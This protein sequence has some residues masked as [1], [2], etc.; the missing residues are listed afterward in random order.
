MIRSITILFTLIALTA[1]PTH[2]QAPAAYDPSVRV[3]F[4]RIWDATAPEKS[5]SV[6]TTRPTKDVRVTTQ[7]LDG[8]GRPIEII[9]QKASLVTDPTNPT[10]LTNATDMIIPYVYDQYGRERYAYLAFA[11]NTSGGNSSI[12]DGLFKLNP[13]QQQKYFFSDANTQSP[14]RGQGDTLFFSKT[15]YESSPLDRIQ[16]VYA[17]G[18]SW[19]GSEVNSDPNTRRNTG[20]E[21]LYNDSNDSVRIWVLSGSCFSTANT[22]VAG[23]LR[24]TVSIDEHK[25]KTVDYTDK[26]GRLVLKK[27]QFSDAPS[28]G[29]YGWLCTY[30]V[31]DDFNLLRGILQPKAIEELL[32][33]GW[34]VTSDIANELTFRYEYDERARPVVKKIPGAGEVWMVYDQWDRLVLSQTAT[35]RPQHQWLFTKYDRLNRPIM[36]GL[37]TNGTDTTLAAMQSYLNTQNLSRYETYQT[38]TFPLYSLTSTFPAVSYSDVHTITYYDDYSWAGWYGSYG[39]KDNTWDNEFAAPSTSSWPYPES[40]A[41]SSLTKGLITGVW[42]KTNSG[43]LTVNYYDPKTR[44]IQ[45][46]TLN[47]TG[48][49]DILTVQYKFSGEV[50]QTVLRHQKSGTNAQ[51]HLVQTRITYDEID[52]PV[53][54]EKKIASTIGSITLSK[55][56]YI[57]AS[58]EYDALGREKKR[59]LSPSYNNGAGLDTLR[60][61]HNIHGWLTAINKGYVEG[62]NNSWFGMQLGYDRD[63]YGP[64]SNKQYNDNISGIIWRSGGDGERRKYDFTY[65]ATKRLLRADFTQKAS[66]SWDLSAGI[67]YSVKLGNGADPLTAYD[68]NGNIKLLLQK[69][70]KLGGSVTIDSLVYKTLTSS[71]K[72]KHV[73]DAA[74]DPMSKLSDFK[75]SAQNNTDNVTS[76]IADYSYDANGN[77][78]SDKNKSI[79]SITYNHLDLPTAVTITNEGSIEYVYSSFGAKLKKIV[80][81]SGKPDKVTLY[82]AGFVYEN[83]QLQLFQYDDGRVRLMTDTGNTYTGYAFDYF[84]RDH[85]GNIRAVLTD[86]KDTAAYPEASLETAK[87]GRDTLYYS[88]I[89]ETRVPKG[90]IGGY[91][92]NDTYTSPNDWIAETNGSGNKIGPGI[93]LK[94]MAGDALNLRVSSWYKLNGASPQSPVSPLS[95]LLANLIASMGGSGKF[96]STELQGSATF[97]SNVSSFLNSRADTSGRPKAYLNWVLFDERLNYVEGS[98][99]FQQVPAETEYGNGGSSPTVKIHNKNGLA[100]AKNGYLYVFVS[101]ETPNISVYF[102][103]LQVTHFKSSLLEES[104]Y[105][106]FGIVMAG[107]SSKAHGRIENRYKF[108]EGAELSSKEFSDGVGMDLYETEFR[109]Y[110][111]QIGRFMHVDP[112]ADIS[113]HLSPYAFAANNPLSNNDPLG[114][115]DT[116]VNGQKVQRDKDLPTV[117]FVYVKKKCNSCLPNNRPT[118]T[119]YSRIEPQ[120]A[121]PSIKVDPKPIPPT[122][123]PPGIQIDKTPGRKPLLPPGMAPWLM[124]ATGT[125]GLV[126]WPMNAGGGAYTPLY[127]THPELVEHPFAPDEWGGHGNDKNNSNPH[128]V[129][130]FSFTP[131]DGQTPILKYGISD[132]F[133]NGYD[134]PEMQKAALIAQFGASVKYRIVT[135]TLNRA[136]ALFLEAALVTKHVQQWGVMPRRQ[137][138][139]KPMW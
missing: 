109:L 66:S 21:R 56:W 79:A 64:F 138:R 107:I 127:K 3:N 136:H 132:V 96:A 101:N 4:V 133:R 27:V 34:N 22:Y 51:T 106:P 24:E 129:Y 119:L 92:T 116:T 125:V 67:D 36:T 2:S 46:K 42:D 17:A 61:E 29:H 88:K 128:I 100:I 11:A 112:L 135:R 32:V 19:V 15:N 89:P 98:S 97:S 43:M 85:L 134:R 41:Q 73:H 131:T 139:P 48:G 78:T 7:Y 113:E 50:L 120:I 104:H 93:L 123:R 25:K 75:E 86:Q 103:N 52:R 91:P 30:Y 83:D 111:P 13:F 84:I 121:P 94:V 8:I 33:N 54:F 49:L 35:L 9:A 16:E 45:S 122:N 26:D 62:T 20:V 74:N 124:R 71:N 47:S 90:E 81:E 80:H 5:P 60:Y 39:S 40:L 76:D 53:Q 1:Q 31:Y 44:L 115:K 137:W 126:L 118:S 108:N 28:T 63:G 105:Y 18:N 10:A 38:A 55:S 58:V 65:D 57:V 110:D 37:Y 95:D 130:E 117:I 114:L 59:K 68:A 77:V 99:G 87:L 82:I 69:G 12:N 23:Q 6:L 102:D 72:L 70:W 14:I